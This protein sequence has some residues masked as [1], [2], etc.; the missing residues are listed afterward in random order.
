MIPK[1][2]NK[3]DYVRQCLRELPHTNGLQKTILEPMEVQR[4]RGCLE[5]Y[6]EVLGQ[7]EKLK[8]RP[9]KSRFPKERGQTPPSGI[10]SL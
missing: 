10:E 6:E 9:N 8:A 1:G 5:S 3:L 2:A 4:I 7:M